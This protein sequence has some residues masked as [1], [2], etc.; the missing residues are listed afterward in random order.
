MKYSIYVFVDPRGKPYY[1][2]KTNNMKRR[3]KEHMAEIANG[4]P[5]PKYAMA[6]RLQRQGHPLRMRVIARTVRESDAYATERALIKKYRKQG[7]KLYNLT[8]G[9]PDEM[10][11]DLKGRPLKTKRV[12]AKRKPAK[13]KRKK[14]PPK[15]KAK[16]INKKRRKR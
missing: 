7:Y 15:K 14:T 12:A 5:L 2:G 8:A 6:R 16:T 9:G 13:T 1:V 10:P 4:N 11:T 3:K